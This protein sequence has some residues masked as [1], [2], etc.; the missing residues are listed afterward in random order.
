MQ[1]LQLNGGV[2]SNTECRLRHVKMA[3]MPR[4]QSSALDEEQP[5]GMPRRS[6]DQHLVRRLLTC[7]TACQLADFKGLSHSV[8]DGNISYTVLSSF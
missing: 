8:Y 5:A 7:K 1:L 6:S 4:Q 3:T 2:S